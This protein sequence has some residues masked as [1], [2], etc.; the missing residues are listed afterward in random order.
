[1]QYGFADNV[2]EELL[3]FNDKGEL[4]NCIKGAKEKRRDTGGAGGGQGHTIL[5]EIDQMSLRSGSTSRPGGGKSN[6]KRDKSAYSQSVTGNPDF[7]EDED[8]DL[9]DEELGDDDGDEDVGEGAST[10]KRDT[11]TVY[12][13]NQ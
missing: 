7:D 8:D 6:K 12:N 4:I 10:Y 2:E 9:D 11:S 13:E 3:Q 1:L 5:D